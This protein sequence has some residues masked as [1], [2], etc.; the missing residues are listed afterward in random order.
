MS[1]TSAEAS[2]LLGLFS[3]AVESS[4]LL[5][6][7]LLEDGIPDVFES[8]LSSGGTWVQLYEIPFRELLLS[9]APLMGQDESEIDVFDFFCHLYPI[10][11]SIECM[12]RYN[13]YPFELLAKAR[14]GDKKSF[15]KAVTVDRAIISGPTG[16]LLTAR[17][18]LTNDEKFFTSLRNS[19]NERNSE[20]KEKHTELKYLLSIFDDMDLLSELSREQAYQLF[21]ED[22][23][24]YP[25]DS[26]D[27]MRSLWKFIRSWQESRST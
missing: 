19:L 24:I 5:N 3:E 14:E 20:T 4:E 6:N 21:V 22:L 25:S 2:L 17:A 7:F 13:F 18:K 8:G 12:T 27:P 9:I 10:A 11:R 15:F 16:A 1:P 23:G 26:S